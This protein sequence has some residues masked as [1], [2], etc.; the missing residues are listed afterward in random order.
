MGTLVLC[1]ALGIPLLASAQPPADPPKGGQDSPPK[2]DD[3]KGGQEK[4]GKGDAPKEEK[5]KKKTKADEALEKIKKEA[6]EQVPVKKEEME[7]AGTARKKLEDIRNVQRIPKPKPGRDDDRLVTSGKA[8]NN[9]RNVVKK[10]VNY[11][12]SLFT[13]PDQDKNVQKNHD[14]ILRLFD[15]KFDGAFYDLLKQELFAAIDEFVNKMVDPKISTAAKV[16][17]IT[18]ID[19]IHLKELARDDE[20]GRKVHGVNVLIN[21]LR[22]HEQHGDAVLY[23]TMNALANAKKNAK[24]NRRNLIAV[25]LERQAAK[26][27]MQIARRGD[28]QPLLLETLCKTLGIVGV[29]YEGLVNEAAEIATFLAN[30]ATNENLGERAR[31]EAAIALGNLQKANVVNNYDFAVEAWVFAKAYQTYLNWV[32]ANR[33]ME[34]PKVSPIVIRHL[35][36]RLYDAI[37]K[38]MDQASGAPGQDRLRTLISAIEPSLKDVFDD[39]DP[40]KEPIAQWIQQNTVPTLKLARRA[41]EIKPIQKAADAAPVSPPAGAAANK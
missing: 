20:E 36:A 18:L 27:L 24:V 40:D 2:G 33:A 19:E 9:Q 32:V 14:E 10:W 35:G 23:V 5:E 11:Q 13:D 39:R 7:K 41:A 3:G 8:T 21:T 30:I 31:L 16:N 6:G 12:L 25:E 1:L 38:S 37:R 22:N 17:M 34:Q 28:L 29:P 4:G 15:Q 26:A